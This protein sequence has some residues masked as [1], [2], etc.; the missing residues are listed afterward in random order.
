[1][2]VK[3]P[4]PPD[5]LEP[6]RT[7]VARVVVDYTGP[8]GHHG[9][10]ELKPV[11]D[12]YGGEIPCDGVQS[13]GKVTYFT[14]ALNRFDLPV[15]IGG[16]AAAP[17]TVTL[18][19]ALSG[20]MPHLPGELPPKSCAGAKEPECK[21]ASDCGAE[22]VECVKGECKARLEAPPKPPPPPVK[23]KGACGACRVGGGDGT[24]TGGI[25]RGAGD[26]RRV[27]RAALAPNVTE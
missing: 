19:V 24:E 8:G 21:V 1:M 23:K 2:L 5:G 20:A 7:A 25:L 26:A 16:T 10:A 11:K 12:G 14:T 17:H 9:Q 6:E 13:A 22:G 4:A 18:K 27:R 3:I 15:A